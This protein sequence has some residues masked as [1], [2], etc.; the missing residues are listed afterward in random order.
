MKIFA[1]R[2]EE[3]L[4]SDLMWLFYFESSKKFYAEL[5]ERRDP[6]DLPMPFD[7][8]YKR[9]ERTVGYRAS[10]RWVRSRLVPP[11]RQNISEILSRDVGI[12][13][14]DEYHLLLH[15]MGRSV[16]DSYYLA[17][18]KKEDLPPEIKMRHQMLVREILPLSER[19]VLSFFYDGTAKIVNL[20]WFLKGNRSFAPILVRDEIYNSAFVLSGGFG[21]AWDDAHEIIYSEL[22]TGGEPTGIEISD[23]RRFV[24]ERT[25]STAEAAELLNCSVQYIN[26]LTRKGVLNPVK[27]MTGNMRRRKSYL[28]LKSDILIQLHR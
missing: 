9:G 17:P 13:E 25:V 2:D 24:S 1:V 7:A 14:Y 11:D 23:L 4:S 3:D 26:E 22:Y 6:F 16:Q 15:A 21:I 19:R 12:K 5:P 27:T 10:L 8:I 20:K 28:Y 18:I